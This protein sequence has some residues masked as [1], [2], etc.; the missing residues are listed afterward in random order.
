VTATVTPG[1]SIG[2]TKS[3]CLT[4]PSIPQLYFTASRGLGVLFPDSG[5]DNDDS[6]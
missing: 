1:P 5:T 2:K 3:E 6:I 4:Y